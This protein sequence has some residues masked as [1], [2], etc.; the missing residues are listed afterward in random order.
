M[1]GYENRQPSG[2]FQDV[3]ATLQLQHNHGLLF[4]KVKVAL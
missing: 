1:E 2:K 3:L 4:V